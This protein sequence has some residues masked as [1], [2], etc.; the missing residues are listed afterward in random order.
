MTAAA[1]ARWPGYAAVRR[2][3]RQAATWRKRQR[4]KMISVI[5]T[6]ENE[7]EV[8]EFL[9]RSLEGLDVARFGWM[10][11]AAD[12]GGGE[13]LTGYYKSGVQDK[14]LAALHIMSDGLY[15][16]VDANFD[17]LMR[18]HGYEAPDESGEDED[19]F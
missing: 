8:A 13:V 2:N 1:S 14:L 10:A 17:R 4:P 19:V 16:I 15:G 3:L 6:D 11:L 9:T 12:I 7:R 5:Y 18:D